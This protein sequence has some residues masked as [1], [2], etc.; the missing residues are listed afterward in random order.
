[1]S[2]EELACAVQSRAPD[3]HLSTIYRNLDELEQLG[4]ITRFHLGHGPSSYLLASQPTP[5]SCAGVRHD[6]RGAGR[7]VPGLAGQQGEPGFRIDPK[8]FAIW[9][10]CHCAAASS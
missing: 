3:V 9:H 7:D 1:M 5:T 6:D 4:V 8:H 10:L 2:A